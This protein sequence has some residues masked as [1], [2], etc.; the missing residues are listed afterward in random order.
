[1]P[2]VPIEQNKSGIAGVTDAKLR[3]ADLSGSGLEALGGGLQMLGEAGG[4]FAERQ[5]ARQQQAGQQQP[6]GQQQQAGE[7]QADQ[8]QQQAQD[9]HFETVKLDAVGKMGINSYTAGARDIRNGIGQLQGAEAIAALPG[10]MTGLGALYDQVQDGMTPAQKSVFGPAL[11]DY[12]H[13]DAEEIQGHV[14]RQWGVLQDHQ[15]QL[16]QRNAADDAVDY[17]ANP[18]LA[19]KHIETGVDSIRLQAQLRGASAATVEPDI[20]QY[21]SGIQLRI[22]DKTAMAD[23]LGAA[24]VLTTHRDDLTEGDLAAARQSLAAPVSQLLAIGDVDRYAM[25]PSP[26]APPTAP[27]RDLADLAARMRFISGQPASGGSGPDLAALAAHYGGD[28]AKAWAAAQL[29]PEAV[30]AVI[31]ARGDAWLGALPADVQGTVWQN[32]LLLNAASS[33]RTAPAAA[34]R[35]KFQEWLDTQTGDDGQPWTEA[36]KQAALGEFDTRVQLA[37]RRA[38]QAADQAKEAGFALADQLKDKFIAITQIPP[39]IRRNLK[40][41]VLAALTRQAAANLRPE[42]V[43]P[44]GR[45][46]LM[47]NLMAA[48]TPAAFAREDLRLWRDLVS[49]QEYTRFQALQQ[50]VLSYPPSNDAMNLRNVVDQMGLHGL[51]VGDG[52]LDD[53]AGG[54]DPRFIKIGQI[55]GFSTGK[56]SVAPTEPKGVSSN[57]AHSIQDARSKFGK[58][59]NLDGIARRPQRI[60]YLNDVVDGDAI[61]ALNKMGSPEDSTIIYSHG[62]LKG[63][64]SDTSR[65]MDPQYLNPSKILG[66]LQRIHYKMGTPI[67]LS[68]CFAA[69]GDQARALSKLTG[70]VVYAAK[71]F[72]TVPSDAHGS[73][74]LSVYTN[75]YQRGD[76]TGYARFENGRET[77]SSLLSVNYNQDTGRWTYI[78]SKKPSPAGERVN[79]PDERSWSTLIKLLFGKN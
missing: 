51:G 5:R 68:S 3:P 42:P 67:I 35:A 73:Y 43:D 66:D 78:K 1:M 25:P 38:D 71:A 15:S 47:L 56:R 70:G 9:A 12:L 45:A 18:L 20:R 49:P 21:R 59:P 52:N 54:N 53:G 62:S 79:P 11:S 28:A 72:V 74:N 40:P 31:K 77:P 76:V 32:M 61:A 19:E 44:G 14:A 16:V 17:A 8:Q 29:G 64:V 65:G 69:S 48:Q 30:D 27:T 37:A 6:A 7:Q 75:G 10:A 58:M 50:G 24:V 60:S 46:S 22:I 26:I 23:A 39:E 2:V 41:E 36:R 33:P 55:G 34:D 57:P 63:T 4:K 13:H